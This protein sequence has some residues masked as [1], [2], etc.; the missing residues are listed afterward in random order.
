MSIIMKFATNFE[1]KN[2]QI[3]TSNATL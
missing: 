2:M 1:D 3:H